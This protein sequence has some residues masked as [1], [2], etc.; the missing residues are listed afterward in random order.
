[1]SLY[2]N[3][4]NAPVKIWGK[5]SQQTLQIFDF[6]LNMP[7][8]FWGPVAPPPYK[9]MYKIRS[10]L[11]P[12]PSVPPQ[13]MTIKSQHWP[14]NI[15]FPGPTLTHQRWHWSIKFFIRLYLLKLFTDLFSRVWSVMFQTLLLLSLNSKQ[16]CNWSRILKGGSIVAKS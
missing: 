15:S 12:P 16:A 3:M 13:N 6:T 1:M 11:P 9:C 7:H 4:A 10:T 5:Y 14:V 8:A 2:L